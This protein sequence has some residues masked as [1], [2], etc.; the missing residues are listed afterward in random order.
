MKKETHTLGRGLLL[1]F[2]IV[3]SSVAASAAGLL[4]PVSST[5]HLLDLQSHHVRVVINNG[6]ARTEVEQVFSNPN[7]HEL[8]AIYTAPVPE[9]GSLAELTIHAGERVLEGEVV[10]K[11]DA[12]RIYED[13][14]SQ[15]NDVGKAD[16]NSYQN[17]EF[18][19][20]PVPAHGSVRM[21]YVYYEPLKIDT[22]VGRYTY[23]LEEGGTDDGATAFWTQNDVVSSDFS[24]QVELKS[25]YPVARTRVPGFG[26]VAQAQEDG[27]LLYRYENQGA[28]LDE[29]FVFYYILEENL[30]GRLEMLTYREN[31]DKSGSFMMIMTP[32]VDIKPL[33]G[34]A[35]FVFALDVSGSMQGKLHTLVSGVKKSIGQLK[36]QD[37][38]R[39]I[40]FNDTAFDL[41]REWVS[42]TQANIDQT[43]LRL[44]Q[45]Q[46]SGGTNVY[47][48]VHLA[49]ERLDADRVATLILVT[50]GVSNRGIV[51]PKEFY[52]IMQRQ[53]LRF[54]GF[55][56]GN[57]SNWPLMQLMCDASG[58]SYRAVSNSDDIIGEVLIAKNKIAFES[59]RHAEISIEGV[60]T[61]DVSDFKIGKIHFGD[62]LVLFGRYEEGGPARV[63][64]KARVNGEDRTYSTEFVFPKVDQSHPEL[65]R[66]WAMD[67]V[68]K[69]QVNQMAGFVEEGEATAAIRDIGVAYQIV[70]DETSM[71]ALDAAGHARHGIDRRNAERVAH[72]MKAR[73]AY[74]SST[75]AQRVDTNAPMYKKK[76]HSMGG[77][78]GA[79]EHWFFGSIAL[80][81]GVLLF[82]KHRRSAANAAVVG[83]I[84]LG[85]MMVGELEAGDLRGTRWTERQPAMTAPSGSIDH[86]IAQFW[87][88]SEKDA[89]EEPRRQPPVAGYVA[90]P[91]KQVAR[92]C[93][94]P[95]YEYD[96]GRDSHRVKQNRDRGS[97]RGHFGLNLFNAIPLV[98]IVWGEDRLDESDSYSGIVR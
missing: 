97:R 59:M 42:A 98:D 71:I 40:A 87:E 56:L 31:E 4:S 7:D 9:A 64:L 47:A 34:G 41:N 90:P 55:L 93:V 81:A 80:G 46:S 85:G 26:G 70:T 75:G 17:F 14:K 22:G 69:I 24:I 20:Y 33:E 78:A 68:R 39:I 21:R 61:H 58:G 32:G 84:V 35:D 66:M 53:D 77:G 5:D 88:V 94:S 60:N 13:E 83:A 1:G 73:Q 27:T 65:E 50:D 72:E 89:R 51:D 92:S 16:K 79:I 36:P 8:E 10:A 91:V 29:D 12:E 19:V 45:L 96:D 57:S 43:L 82:R 37:R 11:A 95:V 44:D 48:G 38:F 52:K 30:P 2:G 86:S 25:A 23:P 67:Q 28:V 63:T 15:G 3:I 62:Q 49:L 18:S 6:F 76:S 54:Y 74:S